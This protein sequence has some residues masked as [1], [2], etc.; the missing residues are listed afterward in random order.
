MTEADLV[1]K[2][3]FGGRRHRALAL[4]ADLVSAR[5]H[6]WVSK[7]TGSTAADVMNPTVIACGPDEDVRAVARR[8]LDSGIKRMPVVEGGELVGIVSRH[9]ILEA[10]TRSD[11]AIAADVGALLVSHPN[12]PDDCHVHY[13]VAGGVVTLS[14]DVRY[15]WDKEIVV[16][17]VRGIAGVIDVVSNLH[18]R[19]PNPRK[20]SPWVL[21]VR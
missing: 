16:A 13:A 8:M 14:G 11:D 12:R 18:N 5:D 10:F 7:A 17:L 1:A 2:E 15:E 6:H 3:A 4:L 20:P 21:G 19:E 9:D